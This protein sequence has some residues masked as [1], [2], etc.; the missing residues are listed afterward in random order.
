MA[1]N[2]RGPRTKVERCG[3]QSVVDPILRSGGSVQKG[4][5]AFTG[6]SISHKSMARHNRLLQASIEKTRKIEHLVDKVC[7]MAGEYD[8]DVCDP[9]EAIAAMARRMLLVQAVEAV[10]EIP[11]EAVQSLSPDKL[12]QMI[13][14]LEYARIAGERLRMQYER[15][16]GAAKRAILKALEAELRER[17]DLLAQVREVALAVTEEA[18]EKLREGG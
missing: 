2:K 14:R 4:Q 11:P 16:F 3:A 18:Q 13:S 9:G 6:E 17:P 7:E 1:G 5:E 15:G 8:P 10:A 12:A